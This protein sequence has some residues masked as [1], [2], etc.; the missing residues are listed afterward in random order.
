MLVTMDM[1]SDTVDDDYASEVM[2][3][4]WNPEVAMLHRRAAE[5]ATQ[6]IRHQSQPTAGMPSDLAAMDVE[7]FLDRMYSSQR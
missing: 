7:N 1:C 4:G 3:A 2:C 6:L 5:L